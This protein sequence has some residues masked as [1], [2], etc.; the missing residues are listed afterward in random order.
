M[1]KNVQDFFYFIFLPKNFETKMFN[2]KRKN[3]VS[4]EFNDEINFKRTSEISD[5]SLKHRQE[6]LHFTE[7]Q[8]KYEAKN[9]Y[10]CCRYSCGYRARHCTCLNKFI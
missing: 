9:T 5:R 4:P 7:N 1:Q 10:H 8:A 3:N 2:S 6:E